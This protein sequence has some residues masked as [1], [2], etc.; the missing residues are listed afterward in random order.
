M[1]REDKV[2]RFPGKS[3]KD[4]N[5][6]GGPKKTGGKVIPF[7]NKANSSPG[8]RAEEDL[9]AM[10]EAVNPEKDQ[11]LSAWFK[12]LN[13]SAHD[14]SR[15]IF[16]INAFLRNAPPINYSVAGDDERIIK[17]Y[18]DDELVAQILNFN[19]LL[20]KPTFLRVLRK[21]FLERFTQVENG[22]NKPEN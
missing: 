10:Q 13:V 21:R 9:Q 22:E 6:A 1:D 11:R 7:K 14:I 15:S 16:A 12:A 18:S 8:S 3:E 2:I 19:R 17:R 20:H 4:S 5:K